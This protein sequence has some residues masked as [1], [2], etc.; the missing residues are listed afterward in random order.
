[1]AVMQTQGSLSGSSINKIVPTPRS[2]MLVLLTS[3]PLV[4]FLVRSH[5]NTLLHTQQSMQ[6]AS[7]SS[8]LQSNTEVVSDQLH[9]AC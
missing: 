4:E 8:V 7:V 1:L 2:H 5:Q 6:T 3:T 9:S